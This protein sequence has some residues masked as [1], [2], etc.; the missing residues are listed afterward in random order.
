MLVDKKLFKRK[1][2][3][4]S[5]NYFSIEKALGGFLKIDTSKLRDIAIPSYRLPTIR[6][7]EF[8]ASGGLD[9]GKYPQGVVSN[10]TKRASLDTDESIGLVRV[11]VPERVDPN[12][13]RLYNMI[14][15]VSEMTA[16]R[17]IAKGGSWMDTDEDCTIKNNIPYSTPLPWLGFRCVCELGRK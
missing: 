9:C 2:N 6:E 1:R 8:A 17:G 5:T 15:N 11:V 3:Q 14:G 13:Y 12:G 10:K 16:Q 7:W 4:D